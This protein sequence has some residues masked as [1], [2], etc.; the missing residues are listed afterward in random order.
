MMRRLVAVLAGLLLALPLLAQPRAGLPPGLARA[1]EVQ[2][3]HERSLFAR[4]GVVAVGLA[5]NAAGRSVIRIFTS[6][7]GIAGLPVR[8]EDQ[9]VEVVVTGRFIAGELAAEAAGTGAPTDRWPRPVPIGVSIGHQDVTA[10]TLG[11]QVYQSSGCH[12]YDYILSNNHVLANKNLGLPGEPILQPGPVDGGVLPADGIA[13]LTQYEPIIFT[14]TASN[15]MDAA[16]AYTSGANVGRGTP[17]DGYGLPRTTAVTAVP[18]L[19]V[20][21]YGRT[22]RNTTGSVI[23]VGATINVDYSTGTARFIDQIIVSGDNSTP[24]SSAG[25]SG[26]LVVVANGVDA[27]R[28]VGLIFAGAGTVSAV[29]PIGPILS[30]FGVQVAG[31]P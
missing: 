14:T 26:S 12:V 10:G 4:E 31:D 1:W 29:N 21:K 24:F 15:I 18:N 22:S 11:C 16:I 19:Q 13:G 7:R 17:A 2:Q 20:R 25:D 5:E 6:R 27:R 8:L 28:P 23:A 30:R 9:D 3:V